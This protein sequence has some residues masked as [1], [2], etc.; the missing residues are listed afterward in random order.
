M[1]DRTAAEPRG[2]KLWDEKQSQRDPRPC[3]V[4]VWRSVY[5][6]EPKH[7]YTIEFRIFRGTLKYNILIAALQLVSSICRAAISIS[8]EKISLISWIGFVQ[9]ITAPERIIYLGKENFM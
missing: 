8:D 2:G 6:P 5:R 9:L 3:E 4:R 1:Q 7:N